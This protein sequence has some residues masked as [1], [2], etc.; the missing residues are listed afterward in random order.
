MTRQALGPKLGQHAVHLPYYIYTTYRCRSPSRFR[1]RQKILKCY[2][3]QKNLTYHFAHFYNFDSD[4]R[5]PRWEFD[6]KWYFVL[7]E[8]TKVFV[9]YPSLRPTPRPASMIQFVKVKN[10]PKKVAFFGRGKPV[11][12]HIGPTQLPTSACY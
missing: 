12:S 6:S 11:R 3:F 10:Y 9:C 4:P 8:S 7:L 5:T 2:F 1:D